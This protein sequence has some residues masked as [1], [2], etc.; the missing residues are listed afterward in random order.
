M[1]SIMTSISCYSN[2]VQF[3]LPCGVGVGGVEVLCSPAGGDSLPAPCRCP[4]A[5]RG[6]GPRHQHGHDRQQEKLHPALPTP[7]DW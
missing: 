4:Q 3:D 1:S 7:H 5:D 6:G 2:Y